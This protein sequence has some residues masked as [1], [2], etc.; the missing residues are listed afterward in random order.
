MRKIGNKITLLF[1]CCT[2][3]FVFATTGI[4]EKLIYQDSILL[5]SV[6][7]NQVITITKDKQQ[8]YLLSVKKDIELDKDIVKFDNNEDG[9]DYLESLIKCE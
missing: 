2:I 7:N 8:N 5:F 4:P 9:F 1:Y 6:L 3:H